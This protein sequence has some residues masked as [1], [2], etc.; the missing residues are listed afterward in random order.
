M[1]LC[2]MGIILVVN[3]LTQVPLGMEHTVS[4]QKSAA[5]E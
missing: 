1:N 3:E 5:A 4:A 2:E